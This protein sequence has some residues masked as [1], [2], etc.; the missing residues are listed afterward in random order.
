MNISFEGIGA[1]CATFL[2][3]GVTEGQVVKLTAAGTVG[4][5]AGGDAFC[6]VAG[7]VRGD[8]CAVQLGGL[9]RVKYSGETAPA[10][11]Y[12]R[13]AADGSGGVCISA[14]GA[15]AQAEESAGAADTGA[16]YLVVD[17]DAADS[18]CVI[19]L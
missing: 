6:G 8:V 16:A 17:V 2:H 13:L 9:A 1:W 12:T 11:G 4:A 5:C 19:K 18:T 15:T 3:G 10:V 14:A 7:A